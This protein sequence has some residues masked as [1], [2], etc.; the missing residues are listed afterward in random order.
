VAWAVYASVL[1]AIGMARQSSALRWVSLM[2]LLLTIG[3]VFLHDLGNLREL[4][5]VLSLLGLAVSLI[6]ASLAYQRFVFRKPARS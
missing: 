1:L 2:F 3:K 4:Y 5:R 6:T